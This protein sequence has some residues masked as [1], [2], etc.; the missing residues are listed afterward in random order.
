MRVRGACT[1]L[2][3]P[4]GNRSAPM[5][6]PRPPRRPR[7]ALEA[8]PAGRALDSSILQST[9]RQCRWPSETA[10]WRH[11]VPDDG[12]C[13]VWSVRRE[14]STTTLSDPAF[15]GTRCAPSVRELATF[16]SRGAPRQRARPVLRDVVVSCGSVCHS[17]GQ[18]AESGAV[19]FADDA[20]AGP[21][22]VSRG[23]RHS[24]GP[25]RHARWRTTGTNCRRSGS[26]VDSSVDSSRSRHESRL[27]GWRVTHE[28]GR[29]RGWWRPC[30]RCRSGRRPTP[31]RDTC[32]HRSMVPSE[33][34]GS[35]RARNP[36]RG[37][38]W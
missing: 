18:I 16:V 19:V 3:E 4:L 24:S 27:C 5:E 37:S 17:S 23:L 22:A 10:R 14:S 2:S 32:Q 34:R 21:A 13:G 31:T 12:H 28:V 36:P 6:A 25:R 11:W 33:H 26:T 35:R 29:S 1:H 9:I 30:L 7:T 38:D 20:G 15:G 8:P